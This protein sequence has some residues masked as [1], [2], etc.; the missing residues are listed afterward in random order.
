M[1]NDKEVSRN[2]KNKEMFKF[3]KSLQNGKKILQDPDSNSKLYSEHKPLRLIGYST[4]P[5]TPW[6]PTSSIVS[7]S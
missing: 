6:D 4:H 3:Y 1:K 5:V 2:F 7:P